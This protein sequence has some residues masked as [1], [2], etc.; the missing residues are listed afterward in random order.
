MLASQRAGSILLL[1]MALLALAHA[2]PWLGG[3]RHLELAQAV[4]QGTARIEKNEIGEVGDD[5]I[6]KAIQTQRATQGFWQA[7]LLLVDLVFEPLAL[8]LRALVTA[9]LFAGIAALGGRP[10]QF[11]RTFAE[12]S[13]A[14]GWWVLGS[15]VRTVLMIGLHRTSV[16]TSAALFL[17][18]GNYPATFWVLLQQVDAFGLLGWLSLALGAGRRGQVAWP[19]ALLA[20]L[21]I[22]LFESLIRTAGF[23]LLEAGPRLS[24]LPAG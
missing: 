7:L 15:V 17:P 5:V 2:L 3:Y 18:P 19:L 9:S 8:L 12:T 23:L 22:A 24:L 13:L 11:P 14:Q 16:E 10:V 6:R 1:W 4:E 20:L 21:P